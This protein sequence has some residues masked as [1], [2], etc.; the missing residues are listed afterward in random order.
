MS[1]KSNLLLT[2][3]GDDFTGSTDAME[4]LC[5]NGVPAV[6]FLEVPSAQRLAQFDG[7]RAI[8]VAGNSRSKS[9]DWM[10][11]NL[12][13]IFEALK[14]LGA[15]V[16]H[17][18]VCSTFDSAPHTGS[19]GRA[20]DI[21]ADIFSSACVPVIVGAPSLRRYQTFGNLFAGFGSAIYRIDRHPVMSAHPITPMH[22][23]D[24]RLHLG[25][26]T[27]R[28]IDLLDI[29]E[30]LGEDYCDCDSRLRANGAQVLFYDVADKESSAR[31]GELLWRSAQEAPVFCAGSSG[32]EYG[33]V[34]YWRR[35][36]H[37]APDDEPAHLR[38]EVDK[39]FVMS[40][41]CSPLTERQ[42]LSALDAG[43]V[44]RQ[45]SPITLLDPDRQE[46]EVETVIADVVAELEA[47]KSV[48]AYTALGAP[49]QEEQELQAR[50]PH[51]FSDQLSSIL[52]RIFREVLKRS[53]IG[54]A[55]VS[56]GDTSSG[57]VAEMGIYALSMIA[58][59]APGA[60]LCRVHAEEGTFDGMEIVL[61]GGQMGTDNFFEEIR[62][63]N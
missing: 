48:V 27:D 39:L 37:I 61:K 13:P 46:S 16:C 44:G 50:D 14:E 12:P 19:I 23:G 42:I 62:R 52:A 2:F 38:S 63:S 26:Q 10:S 33:L 35:S 7:L 60:P 28:S 55:I 58:P 56:G 41:S 17:Y 8:G 57:V 45:I 43:F 5:R 51:K 20:I 59:A 24:L 1:E 18:K 32:V 3:Y 9:P 29:A 15:P 21:G 54:R 40:G 53:K 4:S 31:A 36:G 30:I 22:E 34:E 11:E 6:L 49:T 47:G 25:Q